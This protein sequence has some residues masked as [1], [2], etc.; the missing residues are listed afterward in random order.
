MAFDPANWAT[1]TTG[2][3]VSRNG[4]NY[5]CANANCANAHTGNPSCYPGASGCPWGTVWNSNGACQ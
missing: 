5:T 4:A 1:F 2:A 3:Q